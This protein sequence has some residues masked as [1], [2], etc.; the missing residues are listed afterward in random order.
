MIGIYQNKSDEQLME[1]IKL[2]K[3]QAFDELYLRYSKRLLHFF[4]RMLY[5]DAEKA[6]DFLQDIFLKVVEKPHL[7]D[8]KKRFSTWIFA[9]ANNM[10]K[11]EYRR[12]KVRRNGSIYVGDFNVTENDII[13]PKIEQQIDSQHFKKLVVGELA[14]MSEAKR[15]VF[16]LRYQEQFS[17]KEISDIL[18]CSE[19]TVK[20]R[21]FYTT[22]T[23]AK[24]LQAYNPSVL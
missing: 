24:K 15:S 17:I 12:L 20:S 16:L 14:N 11:N 7:F 1:G 22:K 6:Q 21:L 9:V 3:M 5:K 2:G 19:G 13:L 4:F 18:N 23:L 8:T 10:C